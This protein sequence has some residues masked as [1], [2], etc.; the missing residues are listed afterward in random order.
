[1]HL[2]MAMAVAVFST[3]NIGWSLCKVPQNLNTRR[4]FSRA[5][6][7]EGKF[8]H[9]FLFSMVKDIVRACNNVL[10]VDSPGRTFKLSCVGVVF[11]WSL[12]L[13]C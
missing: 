4:R 3:Q 7:M 9:A 2:T 13:Q 10:A 5:K 6:S 12:G 11:A 1:M 8:H